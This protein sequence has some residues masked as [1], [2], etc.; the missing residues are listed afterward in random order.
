MAA[1]T[2]VREEGAVDVDV[3]A[4][5]AQHRLALVR[6][7]AL[8]VDST[9]AAEDVVHDAFLA[10]H[11]KVGTIRDPQA[12]L[13]YLR[14][15]V[16]NG[17][18]DALRRRRTVRA[19]L[20]VAEPDSAAPADESA[21]LADEHATLLAAVRQLPPRDQEVLLL[22]YWSELSEADIA[23]TLGISRGTV[24]ST[25]SRA[26]DKLQKLLEATR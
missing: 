18:R 23:D 1:R 14:R 10:L 15:S 8:L 21:L 24:K 13:G 5:Y 11:R 26:L 4:L 19:H 20:R 17:A 16:L 3:A 2:L 12:A 22:R 6:M 25:A 7:A 9:P